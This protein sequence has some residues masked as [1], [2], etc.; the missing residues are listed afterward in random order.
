MATF[1]NLRDQTN[2]KST[3]ITGEPRVPPVQEYHQYMSTTSTGVPRVPRVQ[4]TS[5]YQWVSVYQVYQEDQDQIRGATYISD[6]VFYFPE[7]QL[8]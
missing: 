6:V 1:G 2:T 7:D 3:E 8:F 4:G 5:G